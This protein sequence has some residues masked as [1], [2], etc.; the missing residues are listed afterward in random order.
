M[1]R[2]TEIVILLIFL[3][4]LLLIWIDINPPKRFGFVGY[5]ILVYNAIPFPYVDLIIH[6]NGIPTT[7]GSKDHLISESEISALEKENP[8]TIVI[9]SGFNGMAKIEDGVMKKYNN[10]EVFTTSEAV[11]RF[12]ELKSQGKNVAGIFHSTC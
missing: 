9:G 3:S 5:G 4:F 10:I 6:T 2:L 7:R 12:N 8:D 11:K 1:S